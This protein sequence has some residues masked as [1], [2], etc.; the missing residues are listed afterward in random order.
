[1]CGFLVIMEVIF[2][3]DYL[4]TMGVILYDNVDIIVDCQKLRIIFHAS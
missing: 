3:T 1:M 4:V 2:S